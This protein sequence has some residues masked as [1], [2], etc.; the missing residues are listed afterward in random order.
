MIIRRIYSIYAVLLF[1]L[2]FLLFFPAFLLIIYVKPWQKYSFAID[3]IW[4]LLF[5]SLIAMPTRVEGKKHL[6]GK[7]PFIFVANHFSFFD[8]SM[9]SWLGKPYAFV[10][11]ISISK[12]PLFGFMFKKLH[13]PIDRGLLKSKYQSMVRAGEML[14]EGRSVVIFPEGGIT[15][16]E[17]PKLMPFKDGAFRLAIEKQIPLVPVT[18]PWNWIILP[19][20]GK[21]LLRWRR[22]AIIFHQ[23]I[24]TKGLNL[25]DIKLLK[26]KAFHCI[27]TEL[28]R[29]NPDGN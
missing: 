14:D 16:T 22:N 10:G 7:G 1:T 6:K 8:I 3:R 26:E 4:G 28:K 29:R 27:G 21:F 9:F 15:T 11:K 18:I 20:D 19:D 24:E 23:P 25:E 5:F 12:V 13:V 2:T 17:A